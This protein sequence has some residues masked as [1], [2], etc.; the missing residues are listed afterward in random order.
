[1]G[2]LPDNWNHTVELLHGNPPSKDT[3]ADEIEKE[4]I[5]EIDPTENERKEQSNKRTIS[6]SD[7]SLSVSVSLSVCLSVC[8]YVFMYVFM[9]VCMN[10]CMYVSMYA[11]IFTKIIIDFY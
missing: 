10:V 8:L 7:G 6:H 4:K 3:P 5:E 2:S 9:Y 1:M 11:M